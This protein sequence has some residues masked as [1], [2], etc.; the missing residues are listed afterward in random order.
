VGLPGF[1]IRWL[2]NAAALAVAAYLLPGITV[3]DWQALLVAALILGLV[4]AVI[5]PVLKLVTCPLIV[6]TAG[7]FTLI[8]NAAMLGLT[9]WLAESFDVGF[10]VDGLGTALLGA[11]IITIVSWALTQVT[12]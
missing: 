3:S 11:V 2:I 12:D 1:L 9:A 10:T 8:I 5:K 6:L 4:N 7:L